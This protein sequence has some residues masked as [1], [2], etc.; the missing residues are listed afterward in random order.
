MT[1]LQ[2]TRLGVESLLLPKAGR[3]KP[4]LHWP[5]AAGPAIYFPRLP[6]DL[7]GYVPSRTLSGALPHDPIPPAVR[8]ARRRTDG[9]DRLRRRVRLHHRQRLVRRGLDSPSRSSPTRPPQV[10]YDEIIPAVQ[11]DRRRRGRRLQ[12]L[13]R[14]LRRAEPRRRGRP[15]RPTSSRSRSSPTWTRLVEAG[16][17]DADWSTTR[18]ARASSR[19]R[20]VSFIVRKGNPKGIKTWDDL[21]KPGVEV[22][23]PNP[24]TSGAAKWNLLGRLRRQERRR[25][26]PARPASTTSSELINKH[27][28]VQ[29]KSGREALQTFTSRHRRRPALLRVRGD[30]RPEEGR[31]AST[32]SSPT[33]RSRSRSRSP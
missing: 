20:V 17:V 28:K 5:P 8:R 9:R 23:T 15:R 29:D 1:T 16:L 14:R 6:T 2:V 3:I 24:F 22:L 12:V 21:L 4:E 18:P 13:L 11:E 30:H 26:E 33:T 32:T 31:G 27:V 7:V 19:P 25:Q 10:V